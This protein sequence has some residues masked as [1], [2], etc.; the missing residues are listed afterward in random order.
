[1][2]GKSANERGRYV[3]NAVNCGLDSNEK[4]VSIKGE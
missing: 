2:I 4:N 1:M 3:M